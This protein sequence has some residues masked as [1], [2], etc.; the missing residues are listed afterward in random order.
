MSPPRRRSGEPHQARGLGG[1]AVSCHDLLLLA[2]RIEEP[3]GVGA[4]SDQR[5]RPE[6]KHAHAGAREHCQAFASGGGENQERKRQ[7]GRELDPHARDERR[8]GSSEARARTGRQR[9]REREREQ[10][11]RVVVGAA[12]RQHQ[13]HGVQADESDGPALGGA[14][15]AGRPRDQRHRRE[16]RRHGDALEGP[17]GA[18][19]AKRSD[20]IAGKREEGPVGGML[21]GPPDERVDRI[22]EGFG[23]H[24]RVRVQ[25]VQAAHAR[26]GD[27]SEDV[28]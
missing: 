9:E 25:P 26:E 22:G 24:M 12:H 27:I 18:R 15:T 28:L 4:E 13:Q 2:D 5:Q 10:Y 23:G 6:R 8:R 7:P 16:A 19:D 1:D 17:Q 11:Q 3:Q 21:E 14:E 20:R